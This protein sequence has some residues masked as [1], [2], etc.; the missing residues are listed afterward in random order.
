M[1]ALLAGAGYA[2]DDAPLAARR[3][4]GKPIGRPHLAGAVL[5]H[6]GNAERLAGEGN[7]DVTSFIRAWLIPGAP[8]YSGAR[9]RRCGGD[10]VDP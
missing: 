9:A 6:P 2:V 5:G 1:G 3:S 4:A 8:A 7:T 10:R